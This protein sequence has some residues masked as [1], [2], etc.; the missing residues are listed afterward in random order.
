MDTTFDTAGHISL[1]VEIGSGD[2]VVQ[3]HAEDRVLVR[4]DGDDADDATVEQ[5]GDKI[6][7][8]GPQRRGGFFSNSRGL[9][10]HVTVPEG[11]DLTTKL[12]SA[13]LVARGPV[14]VAALKSGSGEIRLE[15]ADSEVQI[16]SGSGDVT[17]GV[18]AGDLRTKAGS[19]DVSVRELGGA[20]SIST[21][22]GD[23]EVHHASGDVHVKT[24]SGNLRV[25]HPEGD[26]SLSTASGDLTV[27]LM[28]AGQLAAKNVSG[29]IR[30]GV[31]DG[32][33]VWTDISTLSG[34]VRSNLAGTGQPAEGQ[35]FLELRAKTVS[36]DIVL[37]QR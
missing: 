19:G 9:D 11:T 28:G 34:S 10:V 17:L 7:V 8:I 35:E 24:G 6:V 20:G 18:V 30:V 2:V 5:R 31:P 4:V 27:D 23:V 37:E 12:G 15:T 36:G 33:P 25:H 3:T 1:Y 22:S 14:G 21:G 26:V 29:D 16:E 13:D 32:V